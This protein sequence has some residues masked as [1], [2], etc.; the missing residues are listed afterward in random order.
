VPCMFGVAVRAN[1]CDR[2]GRR[3]GQL[4]AWLNRKTVMPRCRRLSLP[5]GVGRFETAL[6]VA[7]MKER[8]DKEEASPVPD[9]FR[10]GP[11]SAQFKGLPSLNSLRLT[12]SS[13]RRSAHTVRGFYKVLLSAPTQALE[14]KAQAQAARSRARSCHAPCNEIM[15]AACQ[16]LRPAPRCRPHPRLRAPLPLPPA[17][18][19]IIRPARPVRSSPPASPA[20][21][22]PRGL[23]VLHP[24][25]R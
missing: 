24:L 8:R 5:P 18:R 20:R 17:S 23:P 19:M 9:R 4:L 15:Q 1:P 3:C 21:P 25:V 16:K 12:L 2:S 22:P 6:S 10:T 14:A 13:L 7:L 11:G